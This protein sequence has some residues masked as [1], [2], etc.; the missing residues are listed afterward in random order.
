LVCRATGELC[1]RLAA[2]VG[3]G[4]VQ[5]HELVGALTVIV[6]SQ[7]D[8]VAGVADIDEFDAL[9]D[10]TAVDV[11]AGNYA[12]EMHPPTVAGRTGPLR[13]G[14][15]GGASRR[16]GAPGPAPPKGPPGGARPRPADRK[17]PLVGRLADDP[18]R[19]ALGAPPGAQLHEPLE[20]RESPDAT[21]VDEAREP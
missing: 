13:W 17:A 1:D 3:G 16:G 20:V 9:D 19:G 6:R 5:K 18:A 12:L 8:G 14:S 4:D 2:L 11:Q 21:R 15:G 10:A 7:L